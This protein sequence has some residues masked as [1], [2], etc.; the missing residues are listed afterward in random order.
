MNGDVKKKK[1]HNYLILQQARTTLGSHFNFLVKFRKAT[2][3]FYMYNLIPV[4]FIVIFLNVLS[5]QSILN[6]CRIETM[7]SS[8][9]RRFSCFLT[10]VQTCNRAVRLS[11]HMANALIHQ[12]LQTL[13]TE[14]NGEEKRTKRTLSQ[15]YKYR[16]QIKHSAYLKQTCF[17]QVNIFKISLRENRYEH[18][19]NTH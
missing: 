14:G 2:V 17:P 16:A 12:G 11:Y 18:K 10:K 15:S 7:C 19:L 4:T 3:E 13:E 8:Q 9:E 6:V 5:L 1:K